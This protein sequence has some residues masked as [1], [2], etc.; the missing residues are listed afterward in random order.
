MIP[1]RDR[2]AT[3]SEE[4]A[5]EDLDDALCEIDHITQACND[6]FSLQNLN[7]A[8]R[9]ANHGL[10]IILNLCSVQT[11]RQYNLVFKGLRIRDYDR[12]DAWL[13]HGR[14]KGR[15]S[16]GPPMGAVQDEGHQAHVGV[17]ISKSIYSP[18]QIIPSLVWLE[19]AYQLLSGIREVTYFSLRARQFKLLPIAG[20]GEVDILDAI[21]ISGGKGTCQIVEDRTQME[22]HLSDNNGEHFW[23]RR[24]QELNRLMHAIGL[25]LTDNSVRSAKGVHG[26]LDFLDVLIGPCDLELDPI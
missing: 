13:Q 3:R 21:S 9:Y 11:A 6:V 16:W 14:E 10:R 17:S 5:L 8:E 15:D 24:N 25:H 18:E 19:P 7:I 26:T 22:S 23:D 12:S 1:E 2:V 4:M 20:K